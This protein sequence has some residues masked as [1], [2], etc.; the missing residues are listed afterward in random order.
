[1]LTASNFI[2][3]FIVIYLWGGILLYNYLHIGLIDE[4]LVSLLFV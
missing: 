1:M 3:C 4:L 2:T